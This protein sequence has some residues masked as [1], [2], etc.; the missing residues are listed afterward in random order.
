MGSEILK[1][2]RH[3]PSAGLRRTFTKVPKHF[4]A[5]KAALATYFF[6]VASKSRQKG[7]T[8]S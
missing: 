5:A 7:A 2:I 4:T 1:Q 6:S 8:P 3:Q